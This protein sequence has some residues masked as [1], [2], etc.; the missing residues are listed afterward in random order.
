MTDEWLY[1]IQLALED[2]Q[3]CILGDTPESGTAEEA[4]AE[5]LLRVREALLAHLPNARVEI[6]RLRA[7]LALT[8]QL[9]HALEILVA[10]ET[11]R[12]IDNFLAAYR[13]STTSP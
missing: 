13:A 1:Y 3:H 9:A 10:P 5:T 11:L 7:R 6:E 2:A 8:D 4:A 12:T